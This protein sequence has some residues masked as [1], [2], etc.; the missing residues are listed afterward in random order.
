MDENPYQ[1]PTSIGTRPAEPKPGTWHPLT[2]ALIGF[3]GGTGLMAPF[4]LSLD[5]PTKIQGGML[6]GGIL[7]A[8]CGLAYGIK[9]RR[10]D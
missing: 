2:W 4:I 9:Q 5:V 1:P 6:Y 8:I 7:G 10:C 3:A